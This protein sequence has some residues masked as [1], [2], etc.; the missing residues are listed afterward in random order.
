MLFTKLCQVIP[1]VS[2]VIYKKKKALMLMGG[3]DNY[4]YMTGSKTVSAN[5]DG[6]NAFSFVKI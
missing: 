1:F 5:D 2:S 3:G 4:N 6:K